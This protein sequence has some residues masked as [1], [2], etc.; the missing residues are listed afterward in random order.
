MFLTEVGSDTGGNVGASLSD[1]ESL[2]AL[3]PSIWQRE[4]RAGVCRSKSL[5]IDCVCSALPLCSYF[6]GREARNQISYKDRKK[7]KTDSVN[8]QAC[9][10]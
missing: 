9:S 10:C 2:P 6:T 1:F 7:R 8:G 5:Y 4:D 3:S